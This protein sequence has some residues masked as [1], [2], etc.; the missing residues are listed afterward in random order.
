MKK[1]ILALASI[2]VAAAALFA[3]EGR[4]NDVVIQ[5]P[6]GGTNTTVCI[7]GEIA[8]LDYSVD[9]ACTLDL[10]HAV[11]NTV[12]STTNIATAVSASY[13]TLTGLGY[14]GGDDYLKL[15]SATNCA[16]KVYII[17]K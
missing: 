9:A 4:R 1:C 7:V 12:L 14:T 8:R 13:G 6:T 10:V 16:A 17:Y 11:G 5:N 15:T 3:A 2:A